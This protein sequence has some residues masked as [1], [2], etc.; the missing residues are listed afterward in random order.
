MTFS[1]IQFVV[2]RTNLRDSKFVETTVEPSAKKSGT[3]LVRIDRFSFTSN[4]VLYGVLGERNRYFELFPA[5]GDDRIIPAWGLGEV[6]E[7]NGCDVAVGEKLYGFFPMAQYVTL[8][9][10]D[11]GPKDFRDAAAHR[12]NLSLSYNSYLRV[13]NDPSFAG[14]LGDLQP[15]FRPLTMTAFVAASFFA[16]ERFF[17]A[18][19]VILSSASAKVSLAL[20]YLLR[21]YHKD[22]RVT[23]LTSA[24]N[25]PFVQSTGLY[26]T[27]ATY[28][29]L[30][31][32]SRA[33][34]SIFFDVAGD[35]DV[36]LKLH[37]HFGDML[38]HSARVGLANWEA[39][40]SS[41]VL[42]GP[43]HELLFAPHLITR[44]HA[45]W[46]EGEFDRR[47]DSIHPGL[48]SALG[49]WIKIVR[50]KDRAEAQSIYLN[51]LTGNFSA[52]TGYILSLQ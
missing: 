30:S 2:N 10:A 50:N 39:P 17:G 37:K 20:A 33:E 12:K 15:L 32:I 52:D 45:E 51:Y 25:V 43:K 24:K 29:Q 23:G 38:K 3:L 21:T 14:E 41:E 42:P 9:P 1:N 31:S 8:E 13:T 40:P 47:F 48:L 18:T 35:G 36:R 5:S 26:N 44:F 49:N 7:T 28:D 27:I 46:G 19:Q 11:I 4:N 22:I 6:V 34:P 16:E